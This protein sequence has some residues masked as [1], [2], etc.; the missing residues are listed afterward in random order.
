MRVRTLLYS[1]LLGILLP[2]S[3][4]IDFAPIDTHAYT[5]L[6]IDTEHF[7]VIFPDFLEEQG[8]YTATALEYSRQFQLHSLS[9]HRTHRFPVVL[10][11]DHMSP[12][13]YVSILPRRSFF[14]TTDNL[15][16][17]EDWLTQ[18]A[19]HE[20]RHMV[21]FEAYNLGSVHAASFFFGEYAALLAFMAP[22]W[23]L[24]GDAVM[25]ETVL[26][27]S[28]RGR[29]PSFTAQIKALF[30]EGKVFDYSKMVLGSPVDYTPSPYEFGY[31]MYAHLRST[32]DFLAPQILVSRLARLPLPVIGPHAA[33]R[34]VSG[35]SAAEVY[36]EAATWY[37]R[38]WEE[39]TASFQY[40]DRHVYSTPI[41]ASYKKHIDLTRAPDG[42]LF[43]AI[44]D[45]EAGYWIVEVSD[46]KETRVCRAYPQNSLS[47]G[48]QY[49]IWDALSPKAK[50]DGSGMNIVLYDRATRSRTTL[51]SRSR[52]RSPT[53][54]PDGTKAVLVEDRLDGQKVLTVISIP[55]G[56]VLDTV[57]I[58]SGQRWSS[59]S[60]T[61]EGDALVMMVYSNGRDGQGEGM[62]IER[63]SMK[64][65]T[66]EQLYIGHQEGLS[67]PVLEDGVLY[68]VSD[69]S[70]ID[71]I[72][73]RMP[74]GR[75]YQAVSR[76]IGAYS[77]CIAPEGLFFVDY[78]S[79]RGT[80][81]ARSSM[82]QEQWLSESEVTPYRENFFEPV[83]DQD[84][85]REKVLPEHVPDITAEAQP[86]TPFFSGNCID[87]WGI[88]PV[89]EGDIG[90]MA[91]IHS[92]HTTGLMDQTLSAF[93]D[94]T[95]ETFGGG[96]SYRYRGFYPD[97]VL[98]VRGEFPRDDSIQYSEYQ[99]VASL[100]FPYSFGML[101]SSILAGAVGFSAGGLLRD[102]NVEP[103]Y[104]AYGNSAYSR[105]RWLFS[106]LGRW[107]YTPE[108]PVSTDHPFSIVSLV[109]PA[110]FLRDSCGLSFGWERRGDDDDDIYLSWARG[111][112]TTDALEAWKASAQYT[113]PIFHPDVSLG[114][115]LYFSRISLTGFYDQ[116]QELHGSEKQVS[117]GAELLFHFYLFQL[118]LEL[119]A[120]VRYSRLL[121][122]Q[123]N[124]YEFVLLGVPLVRY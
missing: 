95:D 106:V 54:S 75:L 123:L 26:S 74:D 30:L 13:G 112:G 122:E 64:T 44:Y 19:I 119:N 6:K 84:P 92:A 24:E 111:Y 124:R 72:W 15:E 98:N 2:L 35:K 89:S 71:A 102:S 56:S 101:G 34:R 118:A 8:R 51:F 12:N 67:S 5:W 33:I 28:G 117:A 88:V 22:V 25:A 59:F 94:A 76:P 79:S 50:F 14:Y 58:P 115:L 77:P 60:F 41:K 65:G 80:V 68:F 49:L 52:F 40:T 20:G 61:N 121:D 83:A 100:E 45:R 96:W 73:A 91:F 53:L 57:V 81:V 69:R 85:G 62:R 23:W 31:L 110:L 63:L 16:D 105:G 47:A 97:I 39:Q 116:R 78:A 109:T 87:S 93:W 120:G 29:R 46:Q 10:N 7:E 1:M 86:Y 55:D 114:A 66:R 104:V 103:V 90:W 108:D 48:G 27:Q 107:E 32:Y 17:A 38:F 3:A 11:P 9:P 99:A 4:Q 70:G 36:R 43:S 113:V 82:N 21:Q 37:T 18:L 42:T